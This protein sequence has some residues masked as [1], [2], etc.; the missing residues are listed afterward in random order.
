M[1][2][3]PPQRHRLIVVERHVDA[4]RLGYVPNFFLGDH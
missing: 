1:G 3:L 4:V 2:T